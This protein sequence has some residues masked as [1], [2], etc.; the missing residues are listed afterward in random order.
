MLG[1]SIC[2]ARTIEMNGADSLVATL[3]AGAVEACF[4]NPGTSEMH[5]VSALDHRPLARVGGQHQAHG[6]QAV[7]H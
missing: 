2:V 3:I 4:T 6:E 7:L 5:I 1:R